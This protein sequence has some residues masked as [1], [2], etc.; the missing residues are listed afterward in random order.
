MNGS[1]TVDRNDIDEDQESPDIASNTV[2]ALKDIEETDVLAYLS[3]L[4]LNGWEIIIYPYHDG[5]KVR[6]IP[7]DEIILGTYQRECST[8]PYNFQSY[9]TCIPGERFEVSLHTQ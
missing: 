5:S 1:V 7:N 9:M 2:L 3:Y 6:C 8:V 4:C